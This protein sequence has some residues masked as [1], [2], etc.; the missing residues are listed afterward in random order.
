MEHKVIIVLCLNY[1]VIL[2]H[3]YQNLRYSLGISYDIFPFT[4]QKRSRVCAK[5]RTRFEIMSAKCRERVPD[6]LRVESAH[7]LT[8]FFHGKEKASYRKKKYLNH[9]RLS[10][11]LI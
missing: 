11:H 2:V 4:H 6:I 9:F 5:Y 1:K 10:R 8:I 3:K 7:M